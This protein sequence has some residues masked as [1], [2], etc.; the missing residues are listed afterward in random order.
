[1]PL[2]RPGRP[3]V[4]GLTGSSVT[5]WISPIPTGLYQGGRN[6]RQAAIRVS[7]E[8]ILFHCAETTGVNTRWQNAPSSKIFTDL[9]FL[10]RE[11]SAEML[12]SIL[13][14]AWRASQSKAAFRAASSGVSNWTSD[15]GGQCD[16]S[17]CDREL[18]IVLDLDESGPT[19]TADWLRFRDFN[20]G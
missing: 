8:R 13:S 18:V 11:R 10:L 19:T 7:D 4:R 17:L 20:N 16:E 14:L 6:K 12:R 2:R 9:L 5:L 3:E 1:M 15:L